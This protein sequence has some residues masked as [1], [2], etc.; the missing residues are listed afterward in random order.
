MDKNEVIRIMKTRQA[1]LSNSYGSKNNMQTYKC[2][3][4]KSIHFVRAN[5][6]KNLKLTISS[7]FDIHVLKSC[8]V[9]NRKDCSCTYLKLASLLTYSLFTKM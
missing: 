5:K 1:K 9:C 7:T 6:V 4:T 2:K 3:M 8:A